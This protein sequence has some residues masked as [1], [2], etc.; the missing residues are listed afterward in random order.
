MVDGSDP[1]ESIGLY[2]DG[3]NCA[4]AGFSMGTHTEES[5]EEIVS[6]HKVIGT[7]EIDHPLKPNSDG[8][9]RYLASLV[10]VTERETASV[11]STTSRYLRDDAITWVQED[12]FDED[13]ITEASYYG[14]LT[15]SI[16]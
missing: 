5:I 6:F 14:L 8:F 13:V 11:H 7:T 2:G 10:E 9:G 1:F 15:T 4:D 3:D 12:Y 16:L